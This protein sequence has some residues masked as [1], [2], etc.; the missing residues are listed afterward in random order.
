MLVLGGGAI[1]GCSG[2]ES[3]SGDS[4]SSSS[5]SSTRGEFQ[6]LVAKRAK[7]AYKVTYEATSTSNGKEQSDSQRMTFAVD[8]D[9]VAITTGDNTIYQDGRNSMV[10]CTGNS[11]CMELPVSAGADATQLS[12]IAGQF[13]S[14]A[15]S[16]DEDTKG[17]TKTHDREIAG[18]DATCWKFRYAVLGASTEAET[19]MD[20]DTGA[21]LLMRWG[22]S[23]GDQ[24]GSFES[25][26][27]E[28]A[29][30]SEED[31]TP[32]STPQKIPSV[33]TDV[34]AP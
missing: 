21:P 9:R 10:M 31:F 4:G 24:S 12:A 25:K 11:Q 18:R 22:G 17:V 34:P 6:R 14:A 30:P 1:A 5:A 19:C 26:A 29:E 2:D 13:M 20:S 7:S 15:E 3:S 16:L 27:V 23:S 33:P 28:F 8:G 32:P